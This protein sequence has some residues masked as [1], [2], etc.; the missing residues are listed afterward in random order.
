MQRVK[1]TL[2]LLGLLCVPAMASAQ[3]VTEVPVAEVEEESPWSADISLNQDA[4]FGFYPFMAGS[5]ALSDLMDFT[6]YSIIWT[7]PGFSLDGAGGFGLWTEVGLGVNFKLLDGAINVNPQVGMLNGSL[8]SGGDKALAGE[9]IVPNITV[10]HDGDFTQAQ[11]Y[12]G[13]YLALR[14]ESEN[15]SDFIHYWAYGGLKPIA[16][17]NSSSQAAGLLTVGAHWE[18]LRSMRGDAANLYRWIGPYVSLALPHGVSL[19][20][21][22]G[23]NLDDDVFALDFYK[24]SV[25]FSF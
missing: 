23:V 2:W 15:K 16:L 17:I 24:A 14:G 5:Y 22:A 20:F 18:Q 12:F 3:T 6:F 21:A 19:R 4:F 7:T 13:Y 9:G 10:D 1:G 8:L 11:F 25:G